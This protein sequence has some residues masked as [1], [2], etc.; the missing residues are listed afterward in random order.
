LKTKS[1]IAGIVLGIIIGLVVISAIPS[2]L[3]SNYYASVNQQTEEFENG[4]LLS[5]G[6]ACDSKNVVG[7]GQNAYCKEGGFRP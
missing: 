5:N 1:K 7:M 2:I 4:V 6:I 3:E